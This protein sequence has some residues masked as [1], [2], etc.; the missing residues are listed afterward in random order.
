MTERNFDELSELEKRQRI[1]DTAP[2]RNLAIRDA[3][4]LDTIKGR[5][6]CGR[7]NGSR[8]YYCYQCYLPVIDQA[9][10]PRVKVHCICCN[11]HNCELRKLK[12]NSRYLYFCYFQLPIKIDIVKHR[13]EIAGKSTAVHAVILA[14]EDVKIY[15][16]PQF[17]EI[18]D[19]EEV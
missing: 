7:C 1:V 14:P 9:Y 3:T 11:Q 12:D 4:I 2:F 18:L 15:T 5:V 6:P 16:Y 19:K 17:P 13:C 10:F 8:K